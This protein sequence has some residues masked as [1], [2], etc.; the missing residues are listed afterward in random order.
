MKNKKKISSLL[1][2]A[3]VLSHKL[4]QGETRSKQ[5]LEYKIDTGNLKTSH[6]IISNKI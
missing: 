2:N 4:C 5:Q 6:I 3:Q 1:T